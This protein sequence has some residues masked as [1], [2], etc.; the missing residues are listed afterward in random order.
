[1]HLYTDYAHV[2]H[3]EYAHLFDYH[4]EFNFY[5]RFLRE[6]KCKRIVELACGTGLLAFEFIKNGSYDYLGIDLNEEML[7]IARET[8]PTGQFL[9]GD[10][11]N[12]DSKFNDNFDA[13]LIVGRSFS[14]LVTNTDIFNCLATVNRILKAGGI[15]IFNTMNAVRIFSD[16]RESKDETKQVGDK[17][18]HINTQLSKCLESNWV[19]QSNL[20]YQIT[21]GNGFNEEFDET[22]LLRAFTRDEL[23]LILRLAYFQVLSCRINEGKSWGS[24][25]V[26]AQ[27]PL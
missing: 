16:F 22:M 20:H 26:I 14:H 3:E 4:R 25:T 1:M 12:L 18:Y 17:I 21:D 19:F 9:Q 7:S 27:K 2:Y 5:H 10:M 11:R 24:L 23:K 6:K 8:V 15:F 13:V